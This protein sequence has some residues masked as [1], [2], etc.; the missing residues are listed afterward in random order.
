MGSDYGQGN[1]TTAGGRCQNMSTIYDA[2]YRIALLQEQIDLI[3]IWIL[4]KL[5][6][7]TL[8]IDERYDLKKRRDFVRKRVED[9]KL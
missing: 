1:T 2:R 7:K 4:V 5:R 6:L 8:T 3:I 9:M